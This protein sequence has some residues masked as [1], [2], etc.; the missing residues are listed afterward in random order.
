MDRPALV[1][2]LG[3]TRN[4][5]MLDYLVTSAHLAAAIVSG[6]I[7]EA[8]M[9][10]HPGFGAPEQQ[11]ADLARQAG[12]GFGPEEERALP[13]GLPFYATDDGVEVSVDAF[14]QVIAGNATIEDGGLSFHPDDFADGRFTLAEVGAALAEHSSFIA[15]AQL[16][17]D[18]DAY[19]RAHI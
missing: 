17:I 3:E 8:Q 6:A 15:V 10:A 16:F 11:S 5:W 19:W 13:G 1:A 9:A 4:V 7:T 2:M 18:A 12:L 14:R